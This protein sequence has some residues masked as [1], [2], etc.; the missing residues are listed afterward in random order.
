MPIIREILDFYRFFKSP[1]CEREIV[2]YAENREYY[3]YFEGIIE[4]LT[5]DYG[6]TVSYITSDIRDP[7][8]ISPPPKVQTFYLNSI[9][10]LFMILVDCKVFVMTLTDLDNF[11]L[12]RSV[13]PVH[14]VYVFHSPISVHMGY[15]AEAFD[16]YD[17][18]L[19]TGPYQVEEIR[20]LEEMRRLPHKELVEAG[21]YRLERIYDAYKKSAHKLGGREGKTVLIAPSWGNENILSLYGLKLLE[22]LLGAGYRVIVRPHP[23]MFLRQ[24]RV[25]SSIRSRFGREPRF[26]LEESV[27]SDDSLLRADVMI[28]DY[29]GVAIEYALGTE[30]P[31]LFMDVPPKVRNPEW[32]KTGIEPI[33]LSIRKEIGIVFPAREGE[34]SSPGVEN[35][36]AEE[37]KKIPHYIE[38]LISS[39]EN[40]RA[41]IREIRE[42]MF[43]N[44][45]NSPEAGA[46][47]IINSALN[48]KGVA[49][50]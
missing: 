28:S 16:N 11:Y 48:L 24:R 40:Y 47:H 32:K 39:R 30:R 33:E 14:Y 38:K 18:I 19:C 35:I 6:Q 25:I 34:K 42:K 36:Q 43:F 15:Y 17:S 22:I 50:N 49:G 12:K 26:E 45:G 5:V 13:N 1:I 10:L 46:K 8:L 7:I 21:Y 9:L 29:S 31:V 3:P 37:L 41:R 23:E 44:F 4:K 20:K 27:R 2:F